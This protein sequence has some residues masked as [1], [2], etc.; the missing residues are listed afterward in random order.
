MVFMSY[1]SPVYID[2]L[3]NRYESIENKELED[4]IHSLLR[5]TTI[6]DCKVFQIK[7]S[8]DTKEMKA[9]M[10]GVFGTKRIVLWD[11]TVNNLS[12]NEILSITAHEMGHYI[13]GHMWKII[14]LGGMASVLILYLI[15]RGVIWALQRSGGVFGFNALGDIASLPLLIITGSVIMFIVS[16]IANAYSRHHEMQADTFALELTRDNAAAAS[17]MAKLH[18]NSLILPEP[19]FIYKMWNYSHPTYKDRVE[20]ANTYKPWERGRP[21]KF[22]KYIR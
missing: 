19:G 9:Y 17:S 10:T 5:R 14:G 16:P 18:Y 21:M 3:F 4:K 1:I 15:D 6:G 2:P 13:M 11:T 20:F 22:G 7:K 12:E 8:V